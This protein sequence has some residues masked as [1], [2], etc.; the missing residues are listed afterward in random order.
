MDG[1]LI[2]RENHTLSTFTGKIANET[3]PTLPKENDFHCL[4]LHSSQGVFYI[5]L[6]LQ[7]LKSK[8]L[9]TGMYK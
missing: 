5:Y 4:F 8:Y 2:S 1:V 3:L 6:S 7:T 9:F